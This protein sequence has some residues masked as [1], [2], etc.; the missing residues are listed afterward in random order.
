MEELLDDATTT[1]AQELIVIID[2]LEKDLGL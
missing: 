1:R 2:L